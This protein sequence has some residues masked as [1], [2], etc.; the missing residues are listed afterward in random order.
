MKELPEAENWVNS[1]IPLAMG[2]GRFDGV[3]VG[4]RVLLEKVVEYARS[5][6]LVPACFSFRNDTHPARES[7]QCLTTNAEKVRILEGLG[8]EL[9]LHPAFEQPFMDTTPEDFV[10]LMLID[11]WKAVYIVAGYDFHF[12][13]DR[14]GDAQL[15]K[16]LAE[17]KGVKV[18]ILPP[19]K[20]N[21]K[22]VKAAD[23]R[24]FLKAGDIPRA[25]ELLGRPYSITARQVPGQ[26]LGTRIG[27]PTINFE[28]PIEKVM[29][30]FG[31]YAVNIRW[32]ES[33]IADGVAGFG[34]RPTVE[35]G[36]T[37]PILEVHILDE[38][39]ASEIVKIPETS[40]KTFTIEFFS[41]LRPE[42]I[43]D[44][45]EDL[46]NQIAEDCDQ[47]RKIHSLLKE[48]IHWKRAQE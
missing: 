35:K 30:P 42:K 31:V 17:L 37:T 3:H 23:I 29:P 26:H 13:K 32:G 6:N 20:V 36:R 43:F 2:L 10:N 33:S 12:G 39:A 24:S 21:E 14:K 4:H 27:F 15:L 25:N 11:Q 1:E 28:W 34:F 47:A 5:N 46:K 19:V 40:E 9:L 44:S 38:N 7:H 16:K 45:L 48:N 8:I 22:I 18:E 41:Y